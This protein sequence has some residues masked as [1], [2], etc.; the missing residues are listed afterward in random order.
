M[1]DDKFQKWLARER[2]MRKNL[3][4]RFAV[5][6]LDRLHARHDINYTIETW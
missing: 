4:Y 1:T 3:F 6:V 2:K 5:W